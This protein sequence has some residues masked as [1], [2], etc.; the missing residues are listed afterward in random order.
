MHVSCC[1][2][3]S[4]I[5]RTLSKL[6]SPKDYFYHLFLWRASFKKFFFLLYSMH[7]RGATVRH[8]VSAHQLS[9]A[10]DFSVYM[11]YISLFL[12]LSLPL[13]LAP[14]RYFKMFLFLIL[15]FY[16]CSRHCYLLFSVL[17]HNIDCDLTLR[18]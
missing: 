10:I 14:D 13:S 1:H 8:T 16:Y 3:I 4:F 15:Y 17:V 5:S 11:N 9:C 18:L 2:F 6:I 7:R 12:S